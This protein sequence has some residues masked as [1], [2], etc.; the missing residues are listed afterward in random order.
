MRQYPGLLV[1]LYE[2]A[3][4]RED[5]I[6]AASGDEVLSADDTVLV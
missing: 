5:E 6:R 4:R 2:L 1:E 3:T